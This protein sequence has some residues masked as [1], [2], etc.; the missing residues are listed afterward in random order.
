MAIVEDRAASVGRTAI[1]VGSPRDG[2]HRGGAMARGRSAAVG[3][4]RQV[5][6]IGRSYTLFVVFSKWLL[7]LTAC[8]IVTAVAV[9]P[10]INAPEG[11]TVEAIDP[12]LVGAKDQVMLGPIYSDTDESRQPYQVRSTAAS[13]S[14]A[15]E[16]GVELDRPEAEMQMSDGSILYLLSDVGLYDREGES[17]ELFGGVNLF[18]QGKDGHELRT[19][20]AQVNLADRTARSDAP[21]SGHGPVGTLQAEHGFQVVDGGARIVFR[22]PAKLILHEGSDRLT[23]K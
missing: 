17:L 15:V 9:W 18:H 1:G 11:F 14:Q 3:V 10:Q 19:D 5:R 21:V 6:R 4:G 12:S 13:Q 8:A 7:P 16:G 23:G 20:M 2:R 22:G